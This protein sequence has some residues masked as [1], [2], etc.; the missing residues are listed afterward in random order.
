M[1]GIIAGKGNAKEN[2]AAMPRSSELGHSLKEELMV[3]RIF[4]NLEH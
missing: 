4:V 2:Q 1:N 3:R